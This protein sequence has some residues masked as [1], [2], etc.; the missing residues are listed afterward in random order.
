MQ[1]TLYSSL[2]DSVFL[3]CDH[4]LDFEISS[5]EN[6]INQSRYSVRHRAEIPCVFTKN[7]ICCSRVKYL[8]GSSQLLCVSNR[9]YNFAMQIGKRTYFVYFAPKPYFYDRMDVLVIP[10]KKTLP[11]VYEYRSYFEI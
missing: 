11:V 5:S 9:P 4:G 2:L 7:N 8:Y 6:F 1:S 10:K 3:P